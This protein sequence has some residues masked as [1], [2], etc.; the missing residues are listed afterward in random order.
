MQ[1]YGYYRLITRSDFDGLACAVLLRELNLIDDILFVHPKDMQEGEVAVND[2][3]I[4]ANLPYVPGCHVAFDH[5][6]SEVSRYQGLNPDN[7]ILD[8]R[9]VSCA[10]LIFN[11][12]GGTSRFGR[13]FDGLLAA[14]D[15]CAQG[16][17]TQDDILHPEGWMLLNFLVDPRTGMGRFKQFRVSNY[18]FMLDLVHC[19]RYYPI[20][21]LVQLPDVQERV[22]LYH[23][24]HE[25]A[26]Q[27]LQRCARLEDN[28]VVLDLQH[29]EVIYPVNR[30]MVFLLFPQ[31]RICMHRIWGLRQRNTVFTLT[32]SVFRPEV[33]LDLG[34]LCLGFGGGG[35]AYMAPCQIANVKA[36]EVEVELLQACMQAA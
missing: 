11:H 13:S 36:D 27:Q 25:Q 28:V 8:T 19:C 1:F 3:D 12:F 15:Q 21:R 29:E 32:R 22:Q 35:H 20:S 2:Q 24:Y 23:Q 5:H 18:R 6:A 7:L 30:Y 26:I 34:R 17:Y 33:E 4:T 16:Q 14:V 10:R 9:V 31:A